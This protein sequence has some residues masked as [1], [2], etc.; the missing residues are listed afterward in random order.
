MYAEELAQKVFE[1]NPNI[2]PGLQGEE[3]ILN[4]GF[5]FAVQDLGSKKRANWYFNYDEDFPSDF[6]S[7]YRHLQKMETV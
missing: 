6:V 3:E 4:A 7:N 1:S 2:A 5:P